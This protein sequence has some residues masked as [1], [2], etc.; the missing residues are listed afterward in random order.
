MFGVQTFLG[1]NDNIVLDFWIVGANYGK[2]KGNLVGIGE[3][4]LTQAQQNELRAEIESWD[5]PVIKYTVTT[6]NNGAVA[7]VDSAWY[8]IRSGISLGYKF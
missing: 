1:S 7:K 3:Y 2:G 5:I 4:P 8:G 6:N